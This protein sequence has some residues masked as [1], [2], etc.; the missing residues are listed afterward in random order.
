MAVFAPRPSPI[1]RSMKCVVALNTSGTPSAVAL[2][3][4]SSQNLLHRLA[5]G[6]FIDQLVQRSHVSHQ[7]IFDVFDANTAH[8]T[9]NERTVRMDGWGLSEKGLEIVVL[10]DLLL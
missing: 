8:D 7:R 10:V 2:R 1:C 4:R 3:M 9:L 5:L 6:E